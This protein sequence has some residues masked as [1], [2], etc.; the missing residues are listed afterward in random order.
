MWVVPGRSPRAEFFAFWGAPWPLGG[1]A[2]AREMLP[3]AP[4]PCLRWALQQNKCR[5]WFLPFTLTVAPVCPG[6]CET[7]EDLVWSLR[8]FA[9]VLNLEADIVYEQSTGE[10]F[11]R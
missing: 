10:E 4:E 6:L 1:V 8:I 5:L 3:A 9:S 7:T 11:L 2:G